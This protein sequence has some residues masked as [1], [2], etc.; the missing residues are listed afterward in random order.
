MK[1]VNCYHCGDECGKDQVEFDH[2]S[3]CC[4]GCKT[5]YEI[6]NQNSLMEFYELNKTPGIKPKSGGGHQ[7]DFLNTP[8]IFEKIIDF[9][10]DGTTLV[11][12]FIPVIH[13]SSCV[14]VLESLQDLHPAIQFSHVNFPQRK[15]Q[16]SYRSDELKLADLAQFLAN[17]GY[18]PSI[19]LENLDKKEQKKKIVL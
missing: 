6:L 16:I 1:A 5:V 11:T 3:F 17:L 9:D 4:L 10:D 7:F 2:K 12:F 15:V 8:Q 14:W 19:N 13:C 18:K